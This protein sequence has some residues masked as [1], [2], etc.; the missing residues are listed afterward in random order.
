MFFVVKVNEFKGSAVNP[1]TCDKNGQFPVILSA[2]NGTLPSNA[3]VISGTVADRAGL[4]I[5]KNYAV[6][7]VLTGVDPIYGEQYRYE[8]AGEVSTI[9]VVTKLKDFGIGVVQNEVAANAEPKVNSF[10][11]VGP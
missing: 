10:E 4:E 9:D 6:K 5:G 2:H 8:V 11:K 1:A 7:V 3:R